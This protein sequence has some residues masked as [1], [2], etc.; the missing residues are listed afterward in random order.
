LFLKDYRHVKSGTQIK[1]GVG[2]LIAV[3][4]VADVA[5]RLDIGAAQA[6]N[7]APE[8]PDVDVNRPVAAEIIVTPRP[9]SAKHHGFKLDP[10]DWQGTAEV[11][12][13]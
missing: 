1:Q 3:K 6:F 5:H 2:P 7:L 11:R 4:A 12:T 10:D 8:A 13:L 9:C